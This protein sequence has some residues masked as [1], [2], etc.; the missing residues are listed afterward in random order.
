MHNISTIKYPLL[1]IE[2]NHLNLY[3]IDFDDTTL[4]D[5]INK[6]KKNS[7]ICNMVDNVCSSIEFTNYQKK[8]M[9]GCFPNLKLYI[10]NKN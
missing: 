9:I 4:I 3:N 7:F 2:N 1:L 8:M 10:V 6:M 5:F